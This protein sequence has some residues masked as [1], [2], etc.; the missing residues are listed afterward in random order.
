MCWSLQ[1]SRQQVQFSPPT[2]ACVRR[3]TGGADNHGECDTGNPGV[4]EGVI[5]YDEELLL[6]W[7]AQRGF[8]RRRL[9]KSLHRGLEGTE[10]LCSKLV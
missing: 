2:D 4:P 7:I 8:K 10:G 3:L 1:K 6:G 5:G 9:G